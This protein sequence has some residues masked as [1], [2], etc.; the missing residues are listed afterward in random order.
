MDISEIVNQCRRAGTGR[1]R[2]HGRIICSVSSQGRDRQSQHVSLKDSGAVPLRRTKALL[3]EQPLYAFF[4]PA[5]CCGG[6]P[7]ISTRLSRRCHDCILLSGVQD[8]FTGGLA[9]FEE[10]VRFRR[11]RQ[12][13]RP[14]DAQL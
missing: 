5:R 6:S 4:R 3:F 9:A 1:I 13:K 10:L 8:Q 14:I 11:L 2:S 7:R 12:R